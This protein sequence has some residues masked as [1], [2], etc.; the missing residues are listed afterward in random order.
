MQTRD[1]GRHY[2]KNSAVN[3]ILSH[4]RAVR[5]LR[6]MQKPINFVAFHWRP[7][8]CK[9]IITWL[10]FDTS[11]L[12]RTKLCGP[13]QRGASRCWQ[14]EWNSC[15][16]RYKNSAVNKVLFLFSVILFGT[17]NPLFCKNLS[18]LQERV[19]DEVVH[20][21]VFRKMITVYHESWG[22]TSAILFPWT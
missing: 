18:G 17:H 2:R 14:G 10:L 4:L 21:K 6:M 22:I 9:H 20:I 15:Q 19:E 3:R 13:R 8:V 12:K 5:M 11:R 16:R 7:R 1:G